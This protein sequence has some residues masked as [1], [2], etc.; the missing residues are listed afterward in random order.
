M[1]EHVSMYT[2]ASSRVERKSFYRKTE[3]QMFFADFW[4]PYLCEKTLRKYGVSIQSTT[5]VCEM[6]QQITQKLWAT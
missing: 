3:H 5:M 2:D 1:L 6:F 4:Q